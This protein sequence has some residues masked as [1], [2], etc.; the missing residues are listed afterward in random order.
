M[1]A[2]PKS[3][4]AKKAVSKKN[5][6]VYFTDSTT[7][8]IYEIWTRT[9]NVSIIDGYDILESSK[10]EY[11]LLKNH[12][13]IMLVITNRNASENCIRVLEHYGFESDDIILFTTQAFESEVGKY[14]Q[15]KGIRTILLPLAHNN[16]EDFL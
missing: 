10:Q 2:I 6:L 3:K 8:Q 11:E 9:F 13:K 5:V 7:K 15:K 12:Q 4:T 14:A 16:L 1:E